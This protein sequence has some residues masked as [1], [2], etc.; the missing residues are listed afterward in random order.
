MAAF[1]LIIEDD[2]GKQIIVPFAKDV[3][4]IGRKE[5]NTIRLTERNVSRKHARLSKENGHVVVE[6]LS[7]YNG[8]KLNGER[9]S[10]RVQVAEGDTIQIGDYHLAI[11]AQDASATRPVQAVD[12]NETAQMRS[13]AAA[14]TQAPDDDEFA[15]DTQ[16]WEAPAELSPVPVGAAL[17]TQEEPMR[18]SVP[19]SEETAPAAFATAGPTLEGNPF[20]GGDTMRVPQSNPAATPHVL[21]PPA[22]ASFAAASPAV[23][24]ATSSATS[25]AAMPARKHDVE[26]EPTVRQNAAP[27][28]VSVPGSVHIG[29]VP[30]PTAPPPAAISQANPALTEQTETVRAAPAPTDDTAQ[31]RLVVINTIFAGS[32]FPLRQAEQVIGRTD[33]NDITVEHRSVSRNHAKL[34]REGDRIRILDLKSANG[35]LVNDEEVEQAVLQSGDV[36]E[37]GRVRMRFVPAGERFVVSPDEIE[38]ARVADTAGEDFDSDGGTGITNP[39]RPKK[40]SGGEASVDAVSHSELTVRRVPVPVLAGAGF[41]V[42]LLVVIVVLLARGGDD[43]EEPAVRPVV[44]KPVAVA[45]ADPPVAPVDPPAAPADPPPA[46]PVPV[47]DPALAAPVPVASDPPPV[48]DP[49]PA[50]DPAADPPRAPDPDRKKPPVEVKKPKV[51]VDEAIKEART[52]YVQG[53]YKEAIGVLTPLSKVERNNPT[54]WKLLGMNAQKL[55]RLQTMCAAYGELLRLQPT[56]PDAE[57]ARQ[58]RKLANCK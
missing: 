26:L 25:S 6:D 36:I 29:E 56:G 58:N 24:S 3:I 5:G 19:L 31:P 53:K 32:V 44:P 38:R 4:T 22:G 11:H 33:E 46:D 48:A 30:R 37:L 10:G 27:A 12:P 17:M 20:M 55:N 41:L 14:S 35:V 51:D 42:L 45:V 16:R 7:S 50:A 21:A 40:G 49:P 15:G 47:A 13:V 9:I 2:A 54:V 57:Q 8:I 52:F 28:P 43:E 34:V 39:V 1:K 23:S 18:S